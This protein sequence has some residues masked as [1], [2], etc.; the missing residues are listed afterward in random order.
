MDQLGDLLTTR[1][2]QKGWE[3]TIEPYLSWQFGFIH[4]P[5]RHFGNQ[6]V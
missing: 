1:P 5:D 6:L 4:N 3:F 2:I